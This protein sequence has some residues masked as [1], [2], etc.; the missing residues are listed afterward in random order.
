MKDLTAR[1][2]ASERHVTIVTNSALLITLI[3]IIM[4]PAKI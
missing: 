3:Y 4:C 1:T 2:K